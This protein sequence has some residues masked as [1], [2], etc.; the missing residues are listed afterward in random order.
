MSDLK[1]HGR[2]IRLVMVFELITWKREQVTV[3][4]FILIRSN[5]RKHLLV[6]KYNLTLSLFHNDIS[7]LISFSRRNLVVIDGDKELSLTD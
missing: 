2:R 4:Y 5:N 7:T 6:T 3:R 1:E